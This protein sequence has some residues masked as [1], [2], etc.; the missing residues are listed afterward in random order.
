MTASIQKTLENKLKK[1]KQQIG[2]GGHIEFGVA[3]VIVGINMEKIVLR[4]ELTWT[5]QKGSMIKKYHNHML[6]TNPR[7][8]E[9]EPQN[10]YSNNTSV[11]Q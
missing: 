6:Q 10:I 9:E 5:N 11:R 1:K 3:P 2:E 8:C 7:H 4:I